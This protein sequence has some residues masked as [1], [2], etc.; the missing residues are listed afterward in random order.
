MSIWSKINELSPL[1]IYIYIYLSLFVCVRCVCMYTLL[2][3]TFCKNKK[4][5]QTNGVGFNLPRM[6]KNKNHPLVAV[7]AIN[8][9]SSARPS[10]TMQMEWKR[11]FVPNLTRDKK[12]VKGIR[13]YYG[14]L[15]GF[16][17]AFLL[18][19]QRYLLFLCALGLVWSIVQ[20]STGKINV[21]VLSILGVLCACVWSTIMIEQWYRRENKYRYQWGMMRH[22][23]TEGIS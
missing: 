12:T 7:Y 3:C 2:L 9:S 10:P 1:Y 19:Y 6:L 11:M 8:D 16:Y 13:R 14:E 17:F 5:E 21:P 18:H 23:I 15:I 4:N 20:F 22:S